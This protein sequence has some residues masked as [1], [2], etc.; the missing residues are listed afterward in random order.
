MD[1]LAKGQDGVL[2]RFRS[3]ELGPSTAPAAFHGV[4]RQKGAN[5]KGYKW[6]GTGL[7]ELRDQEFFYERLSPRNP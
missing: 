2:R 3:F 4:V 7:G 5:V 6:P 1:R